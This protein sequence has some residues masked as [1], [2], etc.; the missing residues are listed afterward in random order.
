[1]AAKEAVAHRLAALPYGIEIFMWR[2]VKKKL[3]WEK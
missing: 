3:N 2:K 1:M